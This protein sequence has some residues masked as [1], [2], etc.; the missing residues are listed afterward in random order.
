MSRKKGGRDLNAHERDLWERVVQNATPLPKKSPTELSATSTS[1]IEKTGAKTRPIVQ[2]PEKFALG[3]MMTEPK[4]S[5]KP[6]STGTSPAT[7]INMDRKHFGRMTRGKLRPE[8][9]LDLHGMTLAD[10]SPALHRFILNCFSERLRLVLVITGKGRNIEDDGP[11][12][13]RK[14]VLRFQVPIWLRSPSLAHAVLEVAPAHQRHGGA[15]AFYV[16]LRRGR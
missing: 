14:G 7:A 6:D 8:A 1:R 15:G 2:I 9:R 11:I 3:I 16:Y 12:P 5:K 10:A 13:M 4:P